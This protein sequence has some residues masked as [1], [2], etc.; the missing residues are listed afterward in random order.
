MYADN[1][2]DEP[3]VNTAS[4]DEI[5]L[6]EDDQMEKSPVINIKLTNG[7]TIKS[8]KNPRVIRYVRFKEKSDP[9]NY[10]REQLLLYWPWRNEQSNLLAGG[11]SYKAHYDRVKSFL[12]TKK[13]QYDYNSEEIDK[14]MERAENEE[15]N[16]DSVADVAPINAQQQNDDEQAGITASSQF[17]FYDPKRTVQ[18][19]NYDI[20]GD[21][22]VSSAVSD[23]LLKDCI[24]DAEFYAMVRQ[25]N[26]KQHEFFI[27]VNQW[28][29]SK[30]EPLRVFLTGGAGVG[31]S[32]VI[33]A[34]YQ[35]LHRYLISQAVD[36]LDHLRVLR[37]APT[38]TAAYNID[39]LTIHHAFAIPVQQKFHPL[40]AEKANTLYNKYKHVSVVI[41]DE[42]SLLSNF[43]FKQIND[44]L[45]QIKKNSNPFGNVH[46]ILVGDLFQLEPVSHTWIFKNLC[47]GYG[48]LAVNLWN[49]YFD[50]YELTQIMRQKDDQKYAE[51]L[52]RLREGN[53]TQAD[54]DELTK[55]II[56]AT[57]PVYP[58]EAPH[59]FRTNAEVNVY[60]EGVF[61]KTQ[62]EK[63]SVQATS[64]VLGDV[65]DI[66][67]QNTVKHL[68]EDHK[69]TLHGNTGGLKS[70][71]NLAI[72]LHYDCTVNL[73]VDDGLTNG[74]TCVLKRIEYKGESQTPAILWVQFVDS[75]IGKSWRNKY[76]SFYSSN[77][78]EK[79]WTPIF[80]VTRTFNVYRSLVSR[81]QFPLCPS[82]ARTLHKCQGYTLSR[83]VVHMGKR[84]LAGSHYTAFSR[85]TKIDDLYILHLNEDKIAVYDSVKAEMHRLRTEQELQLCYVPVYKMS[86]MSY[87]IVFHNTRSLHAHIE[88]V[89]SDLNCTSGDVICLAETRLKH[90]DDNHQYKIEGFHDIIRNDQSSTG[91]IRPPH[92]IAVYV[93]SS[94]TLL[95]SLHF[96]E[97][98]LEYSIVTI[99]CIENGIVQV[100]PV[101]RSNKCSHK[102]LKSHMENM[103][104]KIDPTIPYVVLGDFNVNAATKPRMI[105]DL[106]GIIGC[107]QLVQD[108]TT[109]YGT[110]IDLIF[111]NIP[112]SCVGT[113]V[114]VHSDHKIV[115]VH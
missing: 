6:I 103:M 112:Q 58:H 91:H 44:R 4:D 74:A 115:T 49:A 71:L 57:D 110:T 55:R 106:E 11:E 27:H 47:E 46:I 87:R 114:S 59:I 18:Q 23:E 43:L 50:M 111:S 13:K 107:R 89:R 109:I 8:R 60:N 69:Y 96:S 62:T 95:E 68:Y 56:P 86:S 25:L 104:L 108:S 88:D 1:V 92:G 51:L 79:S 94:C 22:G 61:M 37:C 73:D 31:K 34:L 14:A 24:P 82:S 99:Q 5:D 20:G 75:Q 54:V 78:V 15:R 19:Q 42:I 12:N 65:T 16:A 97:S 3:P 38:G 66:V 83:A 2:D 9:E 77:N 101:Y 81:Q 52:N 72:S 29:R 48:P 85:V 39:G 93:K 67:R 102:L 35:S 26:E 113:I 90:T 32:V 21:I 30:N 36:E 41:I 33:R 63:A 76:R 53:Q 7:I 84:Q 70:V 28:I 10:C 105:S 17:A 45:Q 98:E 40:I 100:V 80:A 64:I